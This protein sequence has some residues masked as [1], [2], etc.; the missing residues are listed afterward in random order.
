MTGRARIQITGPQPWPVGLARSLPTSSSIPVRVV[1]TP[2][3]RSR[4][5]IVTASDQPQVIVWSGDPSAVEAAVFIAAGANAYVTSLTDLA[6]AVDAVCTGE[7]WFAAVAAAAICRLARNTRHQDFDA[8]A[9][10][11]RAAAQGLPWSLACRSAGLE[12]SQD[13]LTHLRRRL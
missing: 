1:L 11:A 7:T 2:N 3:P 6:A 5:T 9:A 10:A 4:A 13:V 12:Q 8:L